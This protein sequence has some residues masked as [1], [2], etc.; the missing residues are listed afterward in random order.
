MVLLDL[1][2]ENS[3]ELIELF[4]IN[5]ISLVR[6]PLH[7]VTCTQPLKIAIPIEAIE[8]SKVSQISKFSMQF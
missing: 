2:R 3:S 5:I 1:Y 4:S 7:Y 8:L 6:F